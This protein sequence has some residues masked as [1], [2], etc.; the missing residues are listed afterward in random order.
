VIPA[1]SVSPLD[2][3]DRMAIICSATWRLSSMAASCSCFS[4]VFLQACRFLL[5]TYLSSSVRSAFGLLERDSIGCG[6]GG[7]NGGGP[8]GACGGCFFDHGLLGQTEE[9]NCFGHRL[10]GQGEGDKEEIR[11]M[12]AW[13]QSHSRFKLELGPLNANPAEI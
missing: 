13:M 6:H 9:W 11:A 3:V 8:Y 5:S 4:L 12:S 10:T 7:C 1:M 2:Q